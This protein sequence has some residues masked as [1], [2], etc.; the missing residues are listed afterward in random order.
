MNIKTKTLEYKK[1]LEQG[2]ATLPAMYV[3]FKIFILG[4]LIVG[5]TSGAFNRAFYLILKYTDYAHIYF[6]YGVRI[7]LYFWVVFYGG[8]SLILMLQR[9]SE[10]PRWA[11]ASV[12]AYFTASCVSLLVLENFMPFE[13]L[14]SEI[15]N[16]IYKGIRKI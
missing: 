14:G 10:L 11:A 8:T 16:L 9:M 15:F 1:T 12:I 5:V 3:F 2:L 13:I 6:W 7:S 4:N